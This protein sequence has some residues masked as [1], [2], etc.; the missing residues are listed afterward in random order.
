MTLQVVCSIVI[1]MHLDQLFVSG[2]D[3]WSRAERGGACDKRVIHRSAEGC[4]LFVGDV[5]TLL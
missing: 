2:L 4:V 1:C 3:P 5:L